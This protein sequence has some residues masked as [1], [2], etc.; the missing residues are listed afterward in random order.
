MSTPKM[1]E[2]PGWPLVG[3][4]F[5]GL[6]DPIAMMMRG[7][8]SGEPVVQYRFGPY[9]YL[10]VNEPDDVGRVL[11]DPDRAYSKSPSY[12]ALRLIMGEGLVTAEGELWRHQRKLITPAFHHRSLTGY[13]DQMAKVTERFV[14]ELEPLADG[15][16]VDIHRHMMDVT[17]RIV[18][19]TL[20]STDLSSDSADMGAALHELLF[21]ASRYAESLVKLPLWLPTRRHL[22]Y[23]RALSVVD[24]V[25]NRMIEAR[26]RDPQP[27][28]DLLGALLEADMP[29]Q[30]LRDE[31]VTLAVA[32][33]ET[34]A[35]NLTWTWL[36]LARHPRV[37]LAVRKEVMREVGDGPLD[38]DALNRLTYT[39]KV[40][41]EA[42]RLF[43]P[44]WAI[45]RQVQTPTQ[46]AGF[47]VSPGD[48]ALVCQYTLHHDPRFWPDAEAFDPERF[49]PA[50]ADTRPRFS[51]LPFGGGPR[52]CIGKAFALQEAKLILA[53]MI[54]RF[55]LE[56]ASGDRGGAMPAIDPGITLRPKNG[57]QMRLHLLV[58]VSDDPQDNLRL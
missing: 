43:P 12:H 11:L 52:I 50:V 51:Y 47:D 22:R 7:M 58:D 26:R 19:Q 23:R 46:V 16:V 24:G 15:R 36:L 6:G 25:I 49:R 14:D 37:A 4:M 9:R 21:F 42:L 54:R 10:L 33:H 8:H 45:E 3:H 31:L 39:D 34:T 28:T 32:G 41:H 2:P 55:V 48:I 57:V 5:E 17:F 29:T 44:A 40:V 18:G 1:Y 53:A 20:F 13:V 56:E 35:V 27:P 30:Q 38:T